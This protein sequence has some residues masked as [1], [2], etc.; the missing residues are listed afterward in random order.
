MVMQAAVDFLVGGSNPGAADTAAAPPAVST[1]QDSNRRPKNLQLSA[2]PF[3]RGWMRHK[4]VSHCLEPSQQ[5]L[6]DPPPTPP[7][8][9]VSSG[10][11]G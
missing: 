11:R 10:F 4:C 7:L 2:L 9:K 8:K 1:H 6:L 5:K 3:D